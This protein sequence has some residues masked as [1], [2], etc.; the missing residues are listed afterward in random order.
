VRAWASAFID[1]HCH[2]GSSPGWYS[3]SLAA[4]H[5][6]GSMAASAIGAWYGSY[7]GASAEAMMRATAD[8]DTWFQA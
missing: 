5:G 7:D 4:E 8:A 1:G 2:G 3:A 6:E